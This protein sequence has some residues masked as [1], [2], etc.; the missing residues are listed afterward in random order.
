MATPSTT[1]R[2]AYMY[3]VGRRKSSAARVRFYKKDEH[4]S[5]SVIVEGKPIAEGFTEECVHIINS[6]VALIAQELG[7]Y[8][9]AKVEG[10][11]FHSQAEAIRLGIA[12]I[13][14]EINPEWRA[15]LKSKGYLT[16][17]PRV[18]ERKKPGLRRARRAPQW[19]KR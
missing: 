13:L 18:K 9:T 14:V 16:R 1:K 12:R 2:K 10:G 6:P 17:D 4:P 5:G 19:S 15:L 8:F 7:G 3:A 11:G